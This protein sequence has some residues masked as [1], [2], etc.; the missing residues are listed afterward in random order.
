MTKISPR[1]EVSIDINY[2]A[3]YDILRINKWRQTYYLF[4]KELSKVMLR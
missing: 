3:N 4:C 2:L 1:R